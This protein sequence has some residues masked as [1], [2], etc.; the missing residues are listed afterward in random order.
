[1]HR[2]HFECKILLIN[3]YLNLQH[4]N[5][6]FTRCAQLMEYEPS[7]RI[8]CD[9]CGAKPYEDP[10]LKEIDDNEPEPPDECKLAK[11]ICLFLKL[12]TI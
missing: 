9:D 12:I 1:M 10:D 7:L 5:T 8:A 6:L 2:K 4:S 11:A 3:L